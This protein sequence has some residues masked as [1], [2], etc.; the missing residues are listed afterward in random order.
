MKNEINRHLKCI[1][2]VHSMVV[3]MFL[4][5]GLLLVGTVKKEKKKTLNSSEKLPLLQHGQCASVPLWSPTDGD[6]FM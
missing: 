4:L 2:E 6:T 3:P 1:Y 5:K